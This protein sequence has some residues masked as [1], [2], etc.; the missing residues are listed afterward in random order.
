MAQPTSNPTPAEKTLAEHRALN[1]LLDEIEQASA[2]AATAAETLP[3][4]LHTLHERLADHFETEEEGGLFEQILELAPEQAHECEKLC[5]EHQGLLTRVD[6]LR[7][8][9]AETRADPGWGASVRAVLGELNSHESRENEL[10]SRVLDG[11]TEA[12]D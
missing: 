9:D 2:D 3:P 11:S 7:T 10:L 12:Q 6:A 1:T 4:R 8:A 5:N